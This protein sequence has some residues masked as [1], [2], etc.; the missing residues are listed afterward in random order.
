MTAENTSS[1]ISIRI[2]FFSVVLIFIIICFLIGAVGLW[3]LSG[4]KDQIK[5]IVNNSTEKIILANDIN[6][7]LLIVSGA[8]K[9]MLISEDGD[10]MQR[11]ADIIE[12]AEK[13]I[14]SKTS[15][16]AVL[17]TNKEKEK[18]NRFQA[19]FSK[20]MTI[21]TSVSTLTMEN[22]N[23]RAA[24]LSAEKAAPL[25]AKL[26]T[27]VEAVLTIYEEEFK[28]ATNLFDAMY[29]A[30]VGE[31]MKQSS[32]LLGGIRGLQ[33]TAQG[34]ILSRST[35]QTQ[36]LI[37]KIEKQKES[38]ARE[39]DA[40]GS[41]INKKSKPDF[42][43][44]RTAFT[45]FIQ[46]NNEITRLASENSNVKAFELFKTEAQKHLTQA[47]NIM[48][49]LVKT[50]KNGLIDDRETSNENFKKAVTLLVAIAL[51]GILIGTVLAYIIIQQVFSALLQSFS[52]A[53]KLSKGNFTSR[54]DSTRND[55]LGDLARHLNR[56]AEN[57]GDLVKNLSQGIENLSNAFSTLTKLADSMSI[58]A[59]GASDKSTGVSVSAN[60]MNE[61]MTSVASGMEETSTNLNTVAIAADELTTTINEVAM[62][63][64]KS[65]QITDEAVSY[66]K[67]VQDKV[68]L[69]DK[70]AEAIGKVTETITDI[71]EQTNLL[72]LNATIEA[73]RAGEAGKG[74]AVVA[75]EIKD[76][77]TQTSKATEDIKQQIHEIQSDTQDTVQMISKVAKIVLD[78]NELS[79]TIAAAIEEQS[80]TT[81]EISTSIGNASQAGQQ[82]SGHIG[83][84]SAV[85]RD[86]AAD[87]TQISDMSNQLFEN[88]SKVNENAHELSRVA[89]ELQEMAGKFE[90]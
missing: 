48:A 54:L 16:L 33:N 9:N 7:D 22:T 3:N 6:K 88:C 74:F 82:I 31:L 28:E 19:D 63:T 47:E 1:R 62:N 25:I 76:L 73:A 29:L 23:F 86:V 38:L 65:R 56:I 27:H 50:S 57:V 40:L 32:R 84:T 18:L 10:E 49:G 34:I 51:I 89:K 58:E 71:S 43:A 4:M 20:F 39:L 67:Q 83:Q 46:T 45:Q 35:A 14:K 68:T 59:K 77:A 15:E 21:N 41:K 72:A 55:E 5:K 37:D 81:R 13:R 69:L 60:E 2:K 90:V 53:E 26:D 12:Q 80:A 70:A 75:S 61:S 66:T 87:V 85:A 64:S 11:Y 36:L 42:E 52:F 17:A 30:E 8:E 79:S 78:V 44:A 24:S